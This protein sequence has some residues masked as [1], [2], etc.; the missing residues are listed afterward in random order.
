MVVEKAIDLVVL[1]AEM[2][3]TSKVAKTESCTVVML[4]SILVVKKDS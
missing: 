1:M 4:A 3:D 2:K